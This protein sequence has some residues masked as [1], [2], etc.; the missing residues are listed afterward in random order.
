MK[1]TGPGNAEHWQNFIECIKTRQR[2]ASDIELCHKSSAVCHLGN[3]AYRSRLRVDWDNEKQRIV[4]SEARKYM[5]REYRKPW[6]V[7]V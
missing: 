3:I 6:R 1:S 2:P 7:V 5:S 4:H